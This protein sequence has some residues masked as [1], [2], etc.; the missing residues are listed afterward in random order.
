MAAFASG[1]VL[2]GT[3]LEFDISGTGGSVPDHGSTAPFFALGLAGLALFQIVL[4]R[5]RANTVN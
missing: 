4:A 1:T 2:N 5:Q 3:V